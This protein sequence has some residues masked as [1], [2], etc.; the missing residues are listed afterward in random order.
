MRRPVEQINMNHLNIAII[1]EKYTAGATRCARDLERHLSGHHSVRYYP[2]HK[3]E[4]MASLLE[5]LNEFAPDIVH[6]HSYYGDLPYQFLANI[7]HRYLTCFTPH[8][9]RPIGAVHPSYV[10]CWNCP[11]N[12]LCFRC[13]LVPRWRK[14]FLLNP[15]FWRRLNKRYVH[16]RTA[17]TLTLI[18]PSQ[19]L[20]QRLMVT[21]FRR[22]FPIHHI[23]YGIDLDHFRPILD[24]RLQLELPAR[25]K[26]ILYIAHTSDKWVSNPRKGLHFLAD[27]FVEII[28]PQYPDALLLVAGEGLVP[29]HPNVKPVGFI[30][31]ENL[32]LFYSSADVFAMPTLADN[33]P[34]TILE[35]MGCGTP[36]V[37]SNIGGV[38]EEIEGGE[39]G[40]LVPPGNTKALG[41]AMLAI[42][43]NRERYQKMSKAARIR[44]EQYFN[45][46]L[47]IQRHE[48]LYQERISQNL[49]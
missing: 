2:R 18:S 22:F 1:N 13:A 7:S 9:P 47:F 32:P 41:Q 8:D 17:N 39:T 34:Y 42:L 27:A 33:L 4:T 29:N 14:V 25:N 20:K 12:K 49:K 6:C 37:A 36:V 38:S 45:I 35:A 3:D 5:D 21:E 30:A 31:Q 48:Q 24:A 16:W 46:E 23:P 28:L 11:H 15:Y 10:V 43:D 40:Y 26:I 44:A 19:W